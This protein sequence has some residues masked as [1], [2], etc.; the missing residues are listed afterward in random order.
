MPAEP[1]LGFNVA[2]HPE[3]AIVLRW[4][5]GCHYFISKVTIDGHLTS[6]TCN[7]LR[8]TFDNQLFH[9]TYI[10]PMS[11]Y[12][13]TVMEFDTRHPQFHKIPHFFADISSTIDKRLKHDNHL[14]KHVS[15]ILGYL[16]SE[17]AHIMF[18]RRLS[19]TRR[20]I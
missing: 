20:T 12:Y 11:Q 14:G 19:K 10:P 7:F 16:S 5:V 8:G 13:V 4:M 3:S 18:R 2:L 6:L 1:A 9:S 15:S 17:L